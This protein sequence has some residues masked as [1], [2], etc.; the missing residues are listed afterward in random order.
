MILRESSSLSSPFF[1]WTWRKTQYS[2]PCQVLVAPFVSRFFQD[3]GTG[4]SFKR[5]SFIHCFVEQGIFWLCLFKA[6]ELSSFVA[7]FETTGNLETSTFLRWLWICCCVVF[8]CLWFT[9]LGIIRILSRFLRKIPKIFIK[10]D[11]ESW[12]LP[13]KKVFSLKEL[14]IIIQK[15]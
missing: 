5:R 8:V 3:G 4:T 7:S 12:K 11:T 6:T 13:L 14:I 9:G 10:M 15:L 2:G 1:L